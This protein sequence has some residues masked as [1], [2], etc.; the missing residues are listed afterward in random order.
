VVRL[1]RVLDVCGEAFARFIRN[2]LSALD[3]W[4]GSISS[5]QQ[6]FTSSIAMCELVIY[7]L[8]T[9]FV[10]CDRQIITIFLY[11]CL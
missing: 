1:Y 8:D 4:K 9:M 6:S 3:I 5:I 11:I 2:T 7:F 10:V